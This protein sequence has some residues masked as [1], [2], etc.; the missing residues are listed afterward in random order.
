MR[1]RAHEMRAA[2]AV[3]RQQNAEIDRQNQD[4][5]ENHRRELRMRWIV[6]PGQ[7]DSRL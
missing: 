5:R 4:L 3:M 6:P 7:H 1:N 2:A